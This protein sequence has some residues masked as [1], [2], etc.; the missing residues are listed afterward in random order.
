MCNI[1]GYVGSRS[2]TPILI[3]MMRRQEGLAGGYYTGI[4]TIHEGK[5]HYAKLMGD[6]DDLLEK[7]DAGALPGNIGILHS[8]SNS[9]GGDEWAHPFVGRLGG[10]PHIAYVAN[11][12]TGLFADRRGEYNKIAEQLLREGYS[13]ARLAT[14]N[15]RYNNLSDGTVAHMSDVM[16]QLILRNLQRCG[17]EV[18]AINDAYC[19]MPTE[20]VG[21]LLSLGD[22][23]GIF[24]SRINFPMMVGFA[25]HGVY[26]GSAAMSFPKDA[27]S[28]ESLPPLSSGRV[29][30]TDV[31]ITLMSDPPIAVPA[32]DEQ[33]IGRAVR[34]VREKLAGQEFSFGIMRKLIVR[35]LELEGCHQSCHL[36]YE[37]LRVLQNEG[38]LTVRTKSVEGATAGLTAPKFIFALK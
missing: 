9:G 3:E 22:P 7:T 10:I 15:Q 18:K 28:I 36:G 8:R 34:L 6:L 32:V 11:G 23:K 2:A 35:E 12:K 13:F 14:E 38:S 25:P 1:A 26:L 4:A 27:E 31:H 33:L 16:C 19:E 24:F 5:F 21:L 30:A 37:A 20:V 17:E 29:S